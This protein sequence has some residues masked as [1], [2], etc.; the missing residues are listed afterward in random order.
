[1]RC[2]ATST[3]S[4]WPWP[5]A[6]WRPPSCSS[7]TRSA[8]RWKTPGPC[9]W[10][11][12]AGHA[13]R[14][15]CTPN[16]PR[17]WWNAPRPRSSARFMCSATPTPPTAGRWPAAATRPEGPP[18]LGGDPSGSGCHAAFT[19]RPDS[20]PVGQGATHEQDRYRAGS[21]RRGRPAVSGSRRHAVEL[22]FAHARQQHRHRHHRALHRYR[23]REPGRRCDQPRIQLRRWLLGPSGC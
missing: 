8:G 19:A 7:R 21:R 11:R 6:C 2:A 13:S 10:C 14:C 22:Q 16:R 17:P 5:P 12:S 20:A 15:S 1:M 23:H 4:C 9:R 18:S 3:A